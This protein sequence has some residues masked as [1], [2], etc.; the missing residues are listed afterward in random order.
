MKSLTD[1]VTVLKGIG[2]SREAALKRLGIRT[3]G[4]LINHLPKDYRDRSVITPI[5]GLSSGYYTVKARV[6]AAP[7]V[8]IKHK[9]TLVTAALSDSTGE[10]SAV[11]FNQPYMKN[12]LKKGEYIFSGEVSYFNGLFTMEQP[13]YEAVTGKEL[14]SGARIV[15]VY[16]LTEGL[17]QKVLRRI[18]RD[19]LDA[20]ACCIGGEVLPEAVVKS[21]ELLD[22]R[23]ALTN[24]HYPESA[25]LFRAARHTLVFTELFML[26]YSL[27]NIRGLVRK[28]PGIALADTDE[29][30]F[31]AALPFRFTAAQERVFGELKADM[32]SGH[33]MNRLVQGDVGSGKTAVAMASM[34]LAAKNGLQSALMAPTE[35][36]AR[37]HYVSL[38]RVF[39]KVGLK[40]GLLT[41]SLSLKEKAA[42]K[43]RLSRGELDIIV[44]THALIVDNVEFERLGLVITD[45]QHRF[46]VRQRGLLNEKGGCP[47][48]VVMTA[49]PIPRTLALILYGDMDIS[50]IDELP[51]GR[52]D[53][54]TNAVNSGYRDR[55]FTFIKKQVDSGG[56]AFIVCPAIEDNERGLNSVKTYAAEAARAMGVKTAIMHGKLR[57]D[58]KNAVM[59]GFASGEIPVLVATTVIEVGIDVPNATVM[60]V[61]NAE[62]FGLSQLHQLRGRVGRGAEQSY[63]ILITDAASDVTKERMKAMTATSDGFKLADLDLRIR[64]PGDFLGTRQHGL[65]ELMIANLYRDGAILK[66][67]QAA[68]K[69]YWEEHGN[70]W[71]GAELGGIKLII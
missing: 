57:Q 21:Q 8:A 6:T 22:R 20:Y 11:W 19:A 64:G 2:P 14:L 16:P 40:T 60:L 48:C 55:V 65:P 4:D 58:E 35:T 31:L 46:G 56:Q 62:Q 45:E 32:S 27:L 37:Q 39:D 3:V 44:G 63:C 9:V 5:T 18:L 33:V 23:G 15:P 36:L 29:R 34:F 25:K 47:H 24:I 68:A 67:A 70:E 53:I 66:E 51:P 43:E 17:S 12:A 54:K 1:N 13:E 10:L 49:T 41:G 71:A 61:E 30:D 42:V 52:K 50:V 26:Q 69:A 59:G 28:M 7:A 38:Q